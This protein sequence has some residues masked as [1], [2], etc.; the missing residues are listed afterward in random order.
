MR[1]D[2][3]SV[4]KFPQTFV[5]IV[6]KDIS[7]FMDLLQQATMDIIEA[8]Q[9]IASRH[10]CPATG[11]NF[12]R[13]LSAQKLLMTASARDKGNLTAA[14]LL[15][16]NLQGEA[17]DSEL[18]PSAE[19]LLHAA[20]YQLNADIGAVLHT[21]SIAATVLS[22]LTPDAWLT[23]QG[24]EMQKSLSGVQTHDQAVQIAIFENNQN[25]QQLADQVRNRWSQQSL[26]WGL[27]VRAHGLYAWG[28]DMTEARRH[29]EGLEFLL[30]CELEMR[31]LQ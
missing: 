23:L 30:A 12:S 21:H 8:G 3:D 13:R 14:D 29:L 15:Q 5:F 2:F 26:H 22:R 7:A 4:M 6:F 31:R 17:I 18:K 19:T 27:L 16:V 11:G 1:F 20:L 9:W 25:M 10:W 28:K 24:Y